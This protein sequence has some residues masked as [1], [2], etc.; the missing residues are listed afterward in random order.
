MINLCRYFLRRDRGLGARPLR[1]APLP[2]A[3]ASPALAVAGYPS[4]AARRRR[5][6]KLFV[7]SVATV[8]VVTLV[9]LAVLGLALPEAAVRLR[10][11]PRPD[12]ANVD[13]QYAW[14]PFRGPRAAT[15]PTAGSST[16]GRA[17]TSRATRASSTTASTT[18]SCRRW[19]RI[20]DDPAHGCGRALWENYEGNNSYGTTMA[21]MLLPF[22]TDGCIG[23]SEGLFFEAS[24][25][26]P[27][28]FLAAAAMSKKSSNPVRELR[29]T[30]ND[31][32]VG[33]PYLQDL[34]IK[35]YMAVTPG[36]RRRG[37]PAARAHPDR[38]LRAVAHLRGGRQRHRRAA[39]G[40]AGRRQRAQRRPARA[41]ARGRY[42]LDAEHRRVGRDAGIGGSVDWQRI[43]VAPDVDASRRR[44]ARAIRPARSTSCEPTTPIDPVAL[45]AGDG[46]RRRHRRAV[47]EVPRRRGRR[48]R[49]GPG[50]LLPELGGVRRRRPVPRGAE[51]DGRHPHV[52][53]RRDDVRPVADRLRRLRAHVLR[54]RRRSSCS[55]AVARCATRTRPRT[56]SAAS[57][58]RR[59][60]DALRPAP[61]APAWSAPPPSRCAADPLDDDDDGPAAGRGTTGRRPRRPRPGPAAAAPLLRHRAGI[62]GA[63]SRGSPE[64]TTSVHAR[65]DRRHPRRPPTR[66][67]R[68]GCASR[69]ASTCRRT[70]VDPASVDLAWFDRYTT[71]EVPVQ[72]RRT[73]RRRPIPTSEGSL[74]FRRR[75][76]G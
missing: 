50:Q 66:T 22:W 59:P 47:G 34:G 12:S 49:P 2:A 51:H 24:G 65:A 1:R 14:G 39:H 30:D 52:A 35:Y 31:A 4:A 62:V 53:G 57:P 46:Q 43:D 21:L 75:A 72:Q 10:A 41:L 37:R 45:P 73:T 48:A 25:T 33:V 42:E 74:T 19:P 11:A 58:R 15:R 18:T 26:T 36:G 55:G 64:P 70:S 17:G 28:H 13:F 56:S 20:G 71:G 5:P 44:P 69:R 29:Y 68:P 16:A 23:S 76:N 60:R 63:E 54:D 61:P 7:A 6:P 3:T 8:V 67:C 27:Y 9:T 32:A 38:D 40:A